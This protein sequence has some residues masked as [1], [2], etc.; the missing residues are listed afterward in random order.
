[1]KIRTRILIGFLFL[2]AAGSYLVMDLVVNDIR[3]RYLEAVEESL[4]D[5]AH[6]M[7]ALIESGTNGGA[8]DVSGLGRIFAKVSQKKISARIYGLTKTD[9]N[10]QAYVT[11]ARGVVLYDS[12]GGRSVGRDF[13]RWNDVYR[14]LRGRYGARSSR[15]VPRDPSTGAL[16]VSAPI[17]RDGRIIGAVTAVKPEDSVT[18]FMNLARRKI[19]T[20][21]VIS[22]AAFIALGWLLSLWIN[23]PIMKIV[24]YVTSLHGGRGS[25]LPK[26]TAPEIRL[27]G[28]AFEEMRRELEG[29]RYIERYLQT[30]THEL[31]SPLSSIRGAA[32]LLEEDLDDVQRRRF[33]RT[34]AAE[35]LRIDSIIERLLR[36]ASLEN[37]TG[38]REVEDILLSGLVDEVLES[39]LPLFEQG[40]VRVE[41]HIAG[42]HRVTGEKFLVAHAVLNLVKNAIRFTP[43][44]GAVR[45]SSR[46]DENFTVIAVTDSGSGIPA[47]ALERIFDRFYSL[48]GRDG[49]RGTGLGLPFVREVAH[50]HGGWA[51]VENNAGGPG[52]TAT[53]AFPRRKA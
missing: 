52:V 26:L 34:I 6:L 25:A 35:S 40:E 37:R 7:A 36:L 14:T 48:P 28:D 49:R 5:T 23:R 27:L 50:I 11:D 41:A 20:I 39:L 22:C 51:E 43:G 44:G 29:R 33:Y 31:K 16:Y 38:P 21:G 32:E 3:P 12:K 15:S 42:S 13:S 4:N 45:V 46:V 2:Y 1:M 8:I 30:L 17:T 53:L 19:I 10:I 9:I 18:L 24:A 47:F